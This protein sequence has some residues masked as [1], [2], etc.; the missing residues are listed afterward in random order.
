MDCPQ[1][2]HPFNGDLDNLP[3]VVNSELFEFVEDDIINPQQFL[4]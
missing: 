3:G 2:R 4:I 1:D